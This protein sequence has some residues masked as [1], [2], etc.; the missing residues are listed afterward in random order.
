MKLSA[1]LVVAVAALVLAPSSW[2]AP[3]DLDLSFG[4]GGLVATDVGSTGAAHAIAVQGDDK[5]I[6]VGKNGADS[7]LVRYDTDGTLDPTFAGDG[8]AATNLGGATASDVAIQ[9]DGKIV[10]V[11]RWSG[12]SSDGDFTVTRYNADGT[13]D[14]SFSGDGIATTDFG[15]GD[16]ADGVMIQA[17]GR[18]VV[19]GS[20]VVGGGFGWVSDFAV[21]RYDTDGTL[22]ATFSGDGKQTISYAD[23]S[24]D[25]ALGADVAIQ[26][27]GR[28]VVVGLARKQ[29]FVSGWF[30]LARLNTN[31]SLDTSFSADGK[32]TTPIIGD[33]AQAVAIQPDGK[34][35]VAG[36]DADLEDFAVARYDTDG[37]LD[38]GFSSDGIATADFGGWDIGYDLAVQSD[39]RLVVA[40]SAGGD[41]GL[42]RFN[43]TGALDASFASDGTRIVDFGGGSQID[44]V[45]LQSDG[46][47]VAA[48]EVQP[49]LLN[50]HTDIAVARLQGGGPPVDLV[51]PDTT[52]TSG[53][54]GVVAT[55]TSTFD[56]ASSEP[57][58]TFQCRVDSQAFATC[59]SPHTLAA[60]ESGTHVFEVRAID[61]SGNIDP[62]PATRAFTVQLPTPP[63]DQPQVA[64]PKPAPRI[65]GLRLAA[66]KITT[67]QRPALSFRLSRA[68]RVK[69][70]ILK[71][72]AGVKKGKRCVKPGKSR[73][74]KRCDLQVANLSRSLGAG[75]R[76]VKLPR[77]GVG[78]YEV[79]I[80]LD[81]R[82]RHRRILRVT[83]RPS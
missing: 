53:P 66:S 26:G 54:E 20:R 48:G 72:K 9:N 57:D 18:I 69:V 80:S 77:L 39:G 79:R 14:S 27:N 65:T 28:L 41:F 17:D 50:S 36:D 11:S 10:V 24:L 6:V 46:K 68:A 37:T 63:T 51:P 34:L 13:L 32:T 42:A 7:V 56:F 22:D 83:R 8:V 21:A 74:G 15:G 3:G 58:S 76:A 64:S 31:G 12:I 5:L 40:G 25:E 38:S 1:G 78:R 70:T 60:L 4:S 35:L 16:R 47:I 61:N 67:K 43:P 30:A 23:E 19:V 75:A 49:N 59:S 82:D 44:G 81:G 55:Q 52:I 62:T 2:A 71:V 29:S 45:A 33:G 73:R